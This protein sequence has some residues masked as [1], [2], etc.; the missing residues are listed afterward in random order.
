VLARETGTLDLLFLG[1]GNAISYEGR[2]HSSFLING[3]YL[4]DAGPTALQQL[5]KSRI[6]P[7]DVRVILISHFHADHF[8]GLPFLLL[9]YWRANREE[10]LHIVGPPGIEA[11]TEELLELAFPGLPVRNKIYRRRYIEIDD[12]VDGE[13]E[14]L[15]FTA[16]EV[17]HVPSL[18]CFG[19]RTKMAGRTLAYSGDTVLCDGLLKLV[20]EAEVLVLDCSH[21]SD[22]VHLAPADLT[23]VMAKAPANATTIVS[24]L[25]GSGATS[26]MANV[27]VAS[28]LSRFSF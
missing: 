20:A 28:D 2:A 15:E 19:Y 21:G 18:R 25:D 9:D 8:F 5:K 1:T 11:R 27:L 4:F 14:G 10:E 3:L 7:G 17:K 22:P 16:F 13:V 26:G 12:G 24:H 6:N 23:T